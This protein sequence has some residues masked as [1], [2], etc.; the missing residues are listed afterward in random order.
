MALIGLCALA[1]LA[2]GPRVLRE[3]SALGRPSR[4]SVAMKAEGTLRPA[5]AEGQKPPKPLAITAESRLLAVEVP[6]SIGKAGSATR[7]AR[8]VVQAASAIN[9][10]IRPLASELRPEVALVVAEIKEGGV[11]AYSPGGPLTRSELELVEGDGDPLL[12]PALLPSKGVEV[13][14]KWIVEEV[15]SRS[16]SGYDVLATNRLEATVVSMDADLARI[17]LKGEIRGA[18]RGGEGVM[19]LEGELTFDCKLNRVNRLSIGRSEVRKPG[20]VEAGL[21][22]QSTLVVERADAEA[23]PELAEAALAGLPV[24]PSPE[25]L[26]LEYTPPGGIYSIRHDRAWHLFHDD[27]RQAVLK[28]LDR[29]EVVAQCNL[30]MGPMAAKGQHLDPSAFREDLKKAIGTRLVAIDEEGELKGAAEDGFRYRIAVKGMEGETPILWYYYLL[31]SPEGRQLVA[32]F[33]LGQA[34]AKSLGDNDLRLI[35][36]LDWTAR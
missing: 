15:G 11:V 9:G 5:P 17:A 20:P 19:R 29:G 21:E 28:R 16:L 27:T 30:T 14:S 24:V 22:F 3:S 10:E 4:V 8:K 36:S 1:M 26:L 12:L 34:Q 18:A 35:G 33:T 23:P 7:V 2:N 32:T 6:L 31:A 13:G 25:M